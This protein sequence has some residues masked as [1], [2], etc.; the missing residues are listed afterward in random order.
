MLTQNTNMD[1]LRA[2]L[3]LMHDKTE[4]I[5]TTNTHTNT[6]SE[7]LTTCTVAQKSFAT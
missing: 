2:I 1:A 5:T 4:P 6:H 3:H 7:G